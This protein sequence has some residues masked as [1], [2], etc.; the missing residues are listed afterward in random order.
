MDSFKELMATLRKKAIENA[1]CLDPEFKKR[2][3]DE[4]REIE[5]HEKR[6]QAQRDAAKQKEEPIEAAQR[7]RIWDRMIESQK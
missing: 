5:E 4:K 2:V 3:E 6:L 1:S 7:K